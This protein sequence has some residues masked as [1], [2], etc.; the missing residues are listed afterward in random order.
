MPIEKW[1]SISTQIL[2]GDAK[3]SHIHYL[4]LLKQSVLIHLRSDVPVGSCLSGGLDSSAIVS[5]IHQNREQYAFNQEQQTFSATS[6]QKQWDETEYIHEVLKGKDINAHYVTPD[7]S[8][9]FDA[10]ERLIWYQDEPFGS[11][12]IYAQWLVFQ[13]AHEK[14]IKVLLDGQGADEVIGGYHY[15][16]DINIANLILQGNVREL[17]SE[18]IAIHKKHSRGYGDILRSS[19]YYILCNTNI[20]KQFLI[21]FEKERLAPKWLN[22]E[23]LKAQISFPLE[24]PKSHNSMNL[25]NRYIFHQ[26]FFTSLPALLHYEDRNSMA[27]SLESRVPYLDHRFVEYVINLP[28]SCKIRKGITKYI[29]RKAL[30]SILPD[31]V[32]CRMDKMG[33]ETPEEFWVC[34]ENSEEFKK[35]L[36]RAIIKSKGIIT[37]EALSLFEEIT[38]GNKKYDGVIWRIIIFGIWMDLFHVGIDDSKINQLESVTYY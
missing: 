27:H 24:V 31:K 32:R 4:S 7:V 26:T 20:G 6:T 17:I 2:V 21:H 1:Y 11:T 5:L 30:N 22:L 29:M 10:I 37:S 23:M 18:I 9:L 19:L 16:H 38:S 14:N 28:E 8:G 13:S 36:E 33:F 15:F 34:N 3:S 25:F 35:Q 12:S